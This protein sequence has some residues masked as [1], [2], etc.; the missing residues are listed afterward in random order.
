MPEMIRNGVG[1]RKAISIDW[2]IIDCAD[3]ESLSSFWCGLLGV[4]IRSKK[5]PYI[6]LEPASTGAA[7]GLQK[8]DEPKTGKNRVHVDLIVEDVAEM[9]RRVEQLGG[10]RVPSYEKGGFLVMADPE[11]NEF[12]VLPTGDFEM[13]D[14]G[15]VGYLRAL[16]L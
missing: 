8:V 1:R 10:T 4:E 6:F 2:V 11:G 7:I 16:D 5:G 13:D 9:A 15:N 3:T 12:C 14:D